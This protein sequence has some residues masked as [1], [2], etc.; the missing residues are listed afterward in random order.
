MNNND[1]GIV[2]LF[3]GI[4][5]VH[6]SV[7]ESELI[8]NEDIRKRIRERQ[9]K[10]AQGHDLYRKDTTLVYQR[11]VNVPIDKDLLDQ[12]DENIHGSE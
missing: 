10:Y 5:K 1:V 2:I 8:Q 7:L 4:T 6:P 3:D 9:N 12:I 11:L